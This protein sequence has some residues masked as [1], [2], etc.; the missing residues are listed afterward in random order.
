MQ[1]TIKKIEYGV[2]H[3]ITTQLH[4]LLNRVLQW[5]KRWKHWNEECW[6]LHLRTERSLKWCIPFLQ[7]TPYNILI[8][9]IGFKM[10]TFLLLNLPTSNAYWQLVIL[11]YKQYLLTLLYIYLHLNCSNLKLLKKKVNILEQK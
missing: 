8:L 9:V 11:N 2:L 10:T 6:K 7:V 1:C 4:W 5:I 3:K